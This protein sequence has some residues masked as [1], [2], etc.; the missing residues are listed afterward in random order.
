MFPPMSSAVMARF[1]SLFV[2]QNRPHRFENSLKKAYT[3]CIQ[4]IP[5][6]KFAEN[7]KSNPTAGALSLSNLRPAQVRGQ[8]SSETKPS[9]Q[10][11]FPVGR[12]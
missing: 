1:S 6:G 9:G 5:S 4:R 12:R 11:A 10:S 2:G 8:S 3:S 7:I